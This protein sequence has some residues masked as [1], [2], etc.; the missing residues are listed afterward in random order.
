MALL[1]FVPWFFN[2]SAVAI[3]VAGFYV[4]GTLGIGLCYHRLLTHR[5]FVC[6]KW[7]EHAFAVLGVCCIQDTPARWVATHRHHHANADEQMD[8]HSPLVNFLWGHF[9]WL[10]M[11]N[12]D[13]LRLTLCERYAKDLLRDPFYRRLEGKTLWLQIVIGS[14]A[15]FFAT[16]YGLGWLQ[17]GEP[18]A[19]FQSGMSFLIWG[20]FVRTVLVWH[21]TWS[22][23][24]V[25]HLWGYRNYETDESSRN[26]FVIGFI[27]SGEG[28]HNNHHAF[29]RSAR[30][31]H[32]WWELDLTWL[33][34][35]LLEVTGLA[36]KLVT[37]STYAAVSRRPV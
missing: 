25:T 6:P 27:A 10:V 21:V 20:V 3:A 2:W 8:P 32:K 11:K 29:P 13:L 7:L 33:T 19:A 35:R 22:V 9:G 31:G 34:I 37:P 14:W 4:F 30:H 23:N 26:N 15:L 36:T 18:W 12:R 24:S 16:G 17:S 5:S 1:A 28:W